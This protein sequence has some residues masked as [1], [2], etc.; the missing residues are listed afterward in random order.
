MQNSDKSIRTLSFVDK[1]IS[2]INQCGIIVR[3]VHVSDNPNSEDEIAMLK[4]YRVQRIPTLI[5]NSTAYIGYSEIINWFRS[6]KMPEH[7]MQNNSSIGPFEPI[8]E[9]PEPEGEDDL[10]EQSEFEKQFSAFRKKKERSTPPPPPT[11]AKHSLKS[12]PKWTDKNKNYAQ[13]V[14]NV[15]QSHKIDDDEL[16]KWKRSIDDE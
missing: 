7:T 15:M 4:K 10:S 14:D 12:T 1:N 13:P 5:A 6:L 11:P 3:C 2:F 8:Q 9:L 16:D